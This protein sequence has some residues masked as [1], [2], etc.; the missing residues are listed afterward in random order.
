MQKTYY[1]FFVLLLFTFK[2]YS[3][4]FPTIGSQAWICS[5][6][7][8]D[9]DVANDRI[10]LISN[11]YYELDLEGNLVVDNNTINDTGLDTYDFGPA[12]AVG[13]DSVVHIITRNGGNKS[14]GFNLMYSKREK[15]GNWTVEENPVG[16]PF[17]RNYVVDIVALDSGNAL[18]AHTSQFPDD[19][20]G[21][22]YFYML[23]GLSTDSLGCLEYPDLDL[24][25][26]DSDFRMEQY[27]DT[28]HIATGK[29][30]P[31]GF[32]YYMKAA[33]DSAMPRNLT[34][35]V[36]GHWDWEGSTRIGMPD[37]RIDE[38]GNVFISYGSYQSVF[39]VKYSNDDSDDIKDIPIF[40]E[41]G[42]WHMDLGLSAIAASS[43]G[44]TLLAVGLRT[45][46][47]KAATSC[48]LRYTYSVDG[49]QNWVYPAEI[50]DLRTHGGE[51]R[52]RPRIKFYN[53][54]FYVFFNNVTG[55]IAMTTIDLKNTELVKATNPVILPEKDT[56][57]ELDSISIE[58]PGSDA[59]FYSF[60]SPY[61]QTVNMLS[62]KFESPFSMTVDGTINT[63]AY[64][65]GYLPSDIVSASKQFIVSSTEPNELNRDGALCLYPVPA[66]TSVSVEVNS[67]YTGDVTIHVHNPL[68]QR[69]YFDRAFKTSTMLRQNIDVSSWSAGVY[70]LV[71][72]NELGYT[73]TKKFVVRN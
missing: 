41:L 5:G 43:E 19:I 35:E 44:D 53:N 21:S 59:I 52:M 25:R 32:V 49:G 55:G 46:G 6:T 18:Y 54:R 17:P 66:T 23:D 15:D 51:G 57:T 38:T 28:L 62:T 24:Y 60:S 26:I 30:D 3:Q 8:F 4:T 34:K 2:V 33:I 27:Q 37:L 42:E 31:E 11:H 14:D 69:V 68:G 64:K 16:T 70:I 12:I 67:N 72:K 45:N 48:A 39:F 40:N 47:T 73:W 29:P 50:P 71:L 63:I 1:L 36:I 22:V 13:S 56:I 7:N 9:V 20:Y 61:S 10:Y 58:S 65:S